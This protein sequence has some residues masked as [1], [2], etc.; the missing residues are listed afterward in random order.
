[1]KADIP[2]RFC[3]FATYWVIPKEIEGVKGSYRLFEPKELKP[4][5][6]MNR[7]IKN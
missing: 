3:N 2:R 6:F 1:M 4:I 5:A 7:L